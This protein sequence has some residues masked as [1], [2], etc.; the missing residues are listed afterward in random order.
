MNKNLLFILALVISTMVFSQNIGFEDWVTGT[1]TNLD[2]YNTMI[3]DEPVNGPLTVIQSTDFYSGMYSLR[4]ETILTAENDTLFGYFMNGDPESMQ[5]GHKLNSL[6]A[7]DS[8]IGYYKY[9]IVP[10]DT[11]L[12]LC[13]AKYLGNPTGG[14][15]YTITGT[16]T[17]WKRFAYP[18]E[19]M[20]ADSFIIAAASSNAIN[21][22]GIAPG[23]YLMLD[24]VFLKHNTQG[25][26]YI[27]N[28]SFE[29]WTDY[30]WEDLA[31]WSTYNN[32]F[33]GQAVMSA[34]K[35]T[36]SYSGTYASVLT[37]LL[38]NGYDTIP[39]AITYGD[40]TPSGPEGGFPYSAQP[41]FIRMHYKLN[42]VGLDTARVGIFF[43]NSGVVF[44][45]YWS[46]F[47][48]NQSTYTLWETSVSLS[49]VPDTV[50]IY[51]TSGDNPGSQF[52]VDNFEFVINTA[53]TDAYKINQIVAF[54]IPAT[55]KLNFE[56]SSINNNSVSISIFD[57]TGKLLSTND[58][59]NINGNQNLSVDISSIPKGNYIYKI[60]IADEI[61]SKQ[62][63]KK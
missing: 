44:D 30:N 62:F 51:L 55:D 52:T 36:D 10:N 6:T 27:N 5:G 29:N 33:I 53:V 12:I 35:T 11:A 47:M 58:F 25:I 1:V 28:H 20:L 31:E 57:L 37:T 3:N 61:Y 49:Q 9:N 13:I 60:K 63:V 43:K 26:E 16:Q 32:Y 2:D 22:I 54:P 8:I 38:L 24:S 4:L 45:Q 56:I 48:T 14:D 18:V 59:G 21:N 46:N 40:W 17:T 19:A 41:E 23:S 42:L 50:F 39:G 7:V 15:I 34:E